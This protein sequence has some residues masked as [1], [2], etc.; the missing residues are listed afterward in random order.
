MNRAKLRTRL[1]QQEGGT[2]RTEVTPCKYKQGA[3]GMC[4]LGIVLQQAV[5]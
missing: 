5:L 2:A 3:S 4:G 1:Y